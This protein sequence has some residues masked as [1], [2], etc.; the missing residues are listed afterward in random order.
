MTWFSVTLS[1]LLMAGMGYSIGTNTST[2]NV[3]DITCCSRLLPCIYAALPG[4]YFNRLTGKIKYIDILLAVFQHI[5]TYA[6]GYTF[7]Y[8][9]NI[10]YQIVS[11]ALQKIFVFKVKTGV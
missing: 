2:T 1:L 6:C 7:L 8:T 5:N 10:R 9:S 4:Q 3:S 11:Y